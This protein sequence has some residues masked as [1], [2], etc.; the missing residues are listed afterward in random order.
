MVATVTVLGAAQSSVRY[1]EGDGYYVS[2]ELEHRRASGWHGKGAAALGLRGH[3]YPKRFEQV[4][5]GYVPRTRIRLGRKRDGAHQHRP[6]LDVTLS[7]PKSVSLEGLVFGERRVV[8]AHDEAVRATLDWIESDLLQTRGYDPATGRRPREPAHGMVAALFRHLTSRNQDPQ[9]HTHCVV[10]N[11][12]R[13]AKGEWRS[14]ETTKIRRSAKLIGAYYRN[15]LAQRLQ[16]LGYAITPTLIGR[17]PGF[18]IAGYDRAFLDA[19]SGRRREILQMLETH[20]L[21]YTPALAQMAA[22]HTR[23]AQGRHRTWGTHPAVARPGAR[24]W[25]HALRGARPPAPS[26]R[27][28][29]GE[30]LAQGAGPPPNLPA[31]VVRNRKRAP[32]LPDI[33]PDPALN[34]AAPSPTGPAAPATLIRTREVGVLEAVARA[35]AA[36]EE[37]MAVFP[38]TELQALVLGHAPGRYTLAEIDAGIARLVREGKLVEAMRRGADRAFVT[39]RALR[40]ERRILAVMRAGRNEGRTFAAGA[41]VESVLART[42][43]TQGQRAAVAAIARAPDWLIGIQGHAGV[44]EDD[45]APCRGG[46][47]R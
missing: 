24:A 39:D 46:A 45:D 4:L 10:A 20:G 16:A 22:L 31:N 15:V 3:V 13:N 12:T 26:A 1:F 38:A 14:L 42:S 32:A 25:P 28:R 11:M 18:E 8:R 44:G 9:L 21:P 6:G 7:A 19:F 36:L 17:I 41:S 23:R 5:A 29:H 47:S 33:R 34:A 27:P 2:M 40:A 43:L 30:A 35:V 37:R